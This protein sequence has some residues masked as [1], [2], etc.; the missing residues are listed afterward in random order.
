MGKPA[1]RIGDMHVCPLPYHVGGP[2]ISG[3]PN[4]LINSIP[5]AR[6]S[7]KATC[8]APPDTIAKGSAGVQINGKP[9]A[10]ITDTTAHGGVIVAGSVNVLIGETATVS[11]KMDT[12]R[13][14]KAP[15]AGVPY[16]KPCQG[17]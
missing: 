8:M 6:V 7:D 13:L 2:I 4:V 5:A 12:P 9:A 3:S 16:C 1:A 14:E 15:E 10:R 17:G 11:T